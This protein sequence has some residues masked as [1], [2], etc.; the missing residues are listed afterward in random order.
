M[1]K[2][3]LSILGLAFAAIALTG[4]SNKLNIDAPYKD[5]TVVYG[6]L[7]Q[8]DTTHYIRINKAFLGQGNAN[9]MAQQYDSINYPAG[10][11][12]VQLQDL[13]SSATVTLGTTMA[14]SVA[15]GIF[16]YPNQIEYYTNE[17]L[18][19][20]DQYKLI[21][22]NNKSGNVVTGTTSL[23]SDVSLSNIGTNNFSVGWFYPIQVT[24]NS[25]AGGDIYQLSIRFYYTETIASVSMV[26]YVDWV[27]PPIVTA[28]NG[29]GEYL[30]Q[31]YTGQGLLQFLHALIPP[32]IAGETRTGDSV[33]ITMATGSQDFSTYESL[34]QPSLG[35]NQDKPFFTDLTNGIGIFSARHTQTFS[36]TVTN[37]VDDSISTDPLTSNLGFLP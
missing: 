14:I 8:N 34:S 3:I 31:N 28:G 1:S 6:L 26:R 7:D 19:P 35:I 9:T 13:S 18:N 15:P 36:R 4:C 17:I 12:T 20:N 2:H 27:F 22:T 33:H 16:S 23:L 32:A 10:E 30:T 24:W 37:P 25:V 21:I 11:L 29:G 5:V